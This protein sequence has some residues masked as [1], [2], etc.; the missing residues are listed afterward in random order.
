MLGLPLSFATP[1]VLTTLLALPLIWWLLRLT[2]PKPVQEPFPPTRILA[3]L[4][5]KQETPAH[6]PWWLILLRLLMVAL[7]I[8]AMAG[9][10]WNPQN[11]AI[12]GKGPVLL[13]IDNSW[14]SG[15][16]W[17]AQM[18]TARRVVQKAKEDNRKVSLL[19]AVDNQPEG[20]IAISPGKAQ[21][22]LE[23]AAPQPIPVNW[24]RTIGKIEKLPSAAL[25]TSIIWLS[26]GLEQKGAQNLAIAL[27]QLAAKEVALYL[28]D[29]NDFTVLTKATNDPE[30][31]QVALKR[32]AGST[33]LSGTVEAYDEKGRSLA[34]TTY[35]FAKGKKS[36]STKFTLPV[37]LRNDFA[38]IEIIGQK[39]AGAVYLLDERFRRRRVGLIS[40]EKSDTAQP[41]LSPLYYIS[42][43]LGPY[44]EIRYP[45]QANSADAVSGLIEDKV[46]ALVLA[47]IGTISDNTS[48]ALLKWIENGGM[49]VRFA[50]PRLAAASADDLVP[51][52]LRRGERNLGGSL[53]WG[54]PQP[55]SSFNPGSPFASIKVPGDVTVSRQVLAEP[56][57]ELP[58][59]TWA[60]L[61]DGTP[62]VTAAK[63]GKGW[64]VLF[65]VT[66]NAAWSNLALSGTFVD[67]LRK[68]VNLSTGTNTTINGS[69]EKQNILQPYRIL[70]GFGALSNPPSSTKPLVI[71]AAKRPRISIENPP[72]LYGTSDGF[73]AQNLLDSS[74]VL[75]IL[76]TAILKGESRTYIA[77]DPQYF[78]PGLLA[79]AL[80]LLALDC[81][82][83]L[84]MAGALS[85][86][87]TNHGLAVLLFSLAFVGSAWINTS[88]A[89]EKADALPPGIE[90]TLTTRLGY[91]ITGISEL[92]E[93][94]RQGLTGLT[95]FIAARTSLEPGAPI[96]VD[97]SKDELSFFPLLYWPI[98]PAAAI[99]SAKTMARI[100]AFMKKGGSVIFDTRDA[101]AGGFGG[102]VV[103]EANQRLR[104][105]L[106]DLDIP[107]LERIP[108]D[109]VLTKAF[110]LLKVFPGRYNSDDF[111]VETSEATKDDSRPV[112]V[113]DG[114]SSI[115]I[116]SNDLAGAWA[117]N[118]EGRPV[119][120]TVPE[121]PA[122][123]IYAYR[124]GVNL[125]M[126]TLTGNYK[127]DQVHLPALMERL[128]Q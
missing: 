35:T 13:V 48:K 39:T 118:A 122:Q 16:V 65:H 20:L 25:P 93:L 71:T 50:G 61:A 106:A 66:A 115:M 9:P 98:D 105:I 67:M 38:R 120:P 17:Q 14:A 77:K 44:S 101:L 56:S 75:K 51:V 52:K 80:V 43:A 18:A 58:Q 64:I 59:N 124:V 36:A 111:W 113:G 24:A 99:P 91:V 104:E 10:I 5:K 29:I 127:S 107:P 95:N 94:S 27:Q 117:V 37:E 74:V 54:T 88:Y 21:K 97:I 19:F 89:Q 7:I 62:L 23:A 4:A 32:L 60:S 86:R 121:N 112:R 102:A 87:R 15:P 22:S 73:I 31:M 8:L 81:L 30:A 70:D 110:Y 69:A 40:G 45:R 1:L 82:A 109:H 6:T 78:K 92:D 47:D 53:T 46:S 41:L 42:R 72:G 34:S 123:R 108:S 3:K 84:W 63:R 90:A 100:D 33:E 83:V 76:T 26:T 103:S 2:P 28:P 79:L 68:V 55:L 85:R 49:L 116:T 11:P 114:V 128:G 57:A 119:L 12:T 96:G 126:Y 125:V